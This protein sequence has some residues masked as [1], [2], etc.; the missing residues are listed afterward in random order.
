LRQATA[1]LQQAT[2]RLQQA[3]ANF[4]AQAM[5]AAGVHHRCEPQF[6]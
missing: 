3:T 4:M 2:A 5:G 1:R 6:G